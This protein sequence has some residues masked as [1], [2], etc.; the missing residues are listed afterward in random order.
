[1]SDDRIYPD[2]KTLLFRITKFVSPQPQGVLA[3]KLGVKEWDISKAIKGTASFNV[4]FKIARG[5]KREFGEQLGK[6]L[7]WLDDYIDWA[8][9]R[10]NRDIDEEWED[11]WFRLKESRSKPSGIAHANPET[12]QDL[13]LPNVPSPTSQRFFDYEEPM[14]RALEGI[15]IHHLP[16]WVEGLERI[17]KTRF[18]HELVKRLRESENKGQETFTMV[19][20]SCGGIARDD[21]WFESVLS[22]AARQMQLR[23]LV[24]PSTTQEEQSQKAHHLL[25]VFHRQSILLILDDYHLVTEPDLDEWLISIGTPSMVVVSSI[26]QKTQTPLREK[27]W[28]VRLVGLDEESGINFVRYHG[29]QRDIDGIARAGKDEIRQVVAQMNGHPDALIL[30]VDEATTGISLDEAA[31]Y[32]QPTSIDWERRWQRLSVPARRIVMAMTFFAEHAGQEGLSDVSGLARDVFQKPLRELVDMHLLLREYVEEFRATRYRIHGLARTFAEGKLKADTEFERHAREAWINYYLSLAGSN[33]TSRQNEKRYFLAL[34]NFRFA[35]IGLEWANFRKL[36]IWADAEGRKEIILDVMIGLVHYLDKLS[37]FRERITYVR[38]AADIAGVLGRSEDEVWLRSD[39]LGWTLMEENRLK[40]A[41]TE[42]Q[43]G[44]NLAL[45]VRDEAQEVGKPW[46]TQD[47]ANNQIALSYAFLGRCKLK[48]AHCDKAIKYIENIPEIT[49]WPIIQSRVDYVKGI[50]ALELKDYD[51]AI[52]WL[53][54][55][56]ATGQLIEVGGSHEL[57]DAYLG[58]GKSG[59][60]VLAKQVFVEIIEAYTP[61]ITIEVIQAYFG[62]AKTYQNMGNLTDACMYAQKAHHALS[63][64]YPAHNLMN[65]INE[66]LQQYC[67]VG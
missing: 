20:L 30:V 45:K 51:E 12:Y 36:L 5:I 49:Y 62:L 34:S 3:E 13:Y 55:S 33:A 43:R 46:T 2:L 54:A 38:K 31:S 10:S 39:G 26:P 40:E 61:D 22:E 35:P 19:W 44:L 23:E 21:S 64:R 25:H 37:L 65:G 41:E 7:D 11:R 32:V 28:Q 52:E 1:M 24:G 6:E 16:V 42:I 67:G 59:D 50:V 53:K 57:G 27:A 29:Q 9:A 15:T 8:S 66:F 4:L 17:G 18:L 14:R 60:Y 63:R 56:A 58:R 48:A 47:V